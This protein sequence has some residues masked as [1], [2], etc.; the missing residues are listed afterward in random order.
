MILV[1]RVVLLH[2]LQ[3]NIFEAAKFQ[4]CSIASDRW[5]AG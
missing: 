5:T 4:C 2:L 1:G 3:D